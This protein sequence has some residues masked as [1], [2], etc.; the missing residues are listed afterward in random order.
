MSDIERSLVIKTISSLLKS[1]SKMFPMKSEMYRGDSFQC[2]LN[3]PSDAL[4][5]ALIIKTR[6]RS[7]DRSE[8]SQRSET[9]DARIAIGIGEVEKTQTK[10][11]TSNGIAFIL[12]GHL[13]DEMKDNKQT[14][15][16]STTDKFQ[17][18]LE[19]E[20]ILLDNILSKTT[21]L[22]CEVLNLKLSGYSEIEIA[23]KFKIG[24]SA[25]NQRSTLGSWNAINSMLDRFDMIYHK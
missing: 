16:I 20:S 13:L 1:M 25:V 22:Q 21:P 3:R 23:R 19:T 6:I 5:A 8:D 12:S 14:F 24:Q 4:R 17:D 7:I 9:L 18:E 2:L 10:I 11:S 15:G